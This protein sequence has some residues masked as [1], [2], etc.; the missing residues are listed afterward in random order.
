MDRA[1]FCYLTLHISGKLVS[2]QKEIVSCI[3]QIVQKPLSVPDQVGVIFL[4][5]VQTRTPQDH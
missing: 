5:T 4:S 1:G 3:M 2:S